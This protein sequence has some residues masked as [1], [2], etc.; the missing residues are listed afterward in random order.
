MKSPTGG[1]LALPHPALCQLDTTDR[2]SSIPDC[3][4]IPVGVQRFISFLL[5][6]SAILLVCTSTTNGSCLLLMVN[7]VILGFGISGNCQVPIVVKIQL[8]IHVPLHALNSL[9]LSKQTGW[10]RVDIQNAYFRAWMCQ[11]NKNNT[12]LRHHDRAR[13]AVFRCALILGEWIGLLSECIHVVKYHIK[14]LYLKS[15]K[16]PIWEE[17]HM[18]GF[19]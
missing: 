8:F 19:W 13:K 12:Y 18:S 15:Q 6:N 11:Q 16:I 3:S 17:Y 9:A 4:S 1:P 10:G 14:G 5:D 7:W 2:C